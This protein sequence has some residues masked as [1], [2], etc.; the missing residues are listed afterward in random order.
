[1]T[2]RKESHEYTNKDLAEYAAEQFWKALATG[3]APKVMVAAHGIVQWVLTCGQARLLETQKELGDE[4][5]DQ[6][7]R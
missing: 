5:A 1:M 7:S 3:G 2:E 4:R 6:A